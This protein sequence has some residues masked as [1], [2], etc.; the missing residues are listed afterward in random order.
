MADRI[1]TVNA[2]WFKLDRKEMG[3]E[4]ARL[5]EHYKKS[6]AGRRSQYVRNL[7]LY[8]GRSLDGYTADSYLDSAVD[9]PFERD[10]MRLVRSAIGSAVANIFAPQKPKPQFQTLGATW[11]TRRKAYRLDRICE[12][13]L[14]QR[15]G[16]WI[17]VWALMIDAGVEC[18]TQGVAPIKV[19]ADKR[20]KRIAHKV[21]PHPYLFTDPS[22]G[23]EPMDLF[24]ESPIDEWEALQLYPKAKKAIQGAKPFEH[25]GR[26]HRQRS[27]KEI[28]IQYAWRLPSGEDDPG[29]WCAVINGEVVDEGEWTAASFPFVFLTWEPHRDGFWASGLADEGGSMAQ[30]CGEIDLRLFMR[31]IVASGKKI[32]YRKSS[33]EPDDLA[34]NDAVVAVPVE[35]GHDYPQESPSIPFA[36]MELEFL[37]YKVQQFWDGIGI[38]QVSAAA[39]REQ[40]VSSG[41]AIMTLNDTKAG[42][43]LVKA[44]RY[45]QA[46]VDL[47]HQY[48]WRLRELAEDDPDFAVQWP[49]KNLLRSEKWADAE[50]DD[51]EF[52]VTVAPA[53]SLPHDPAGRQEMVQAMF[54]SGL[55]SQETAKSLIGWPD[56]DSE[57]EAENSEYEYIDML[58]A[59]YLDADEETW[60][61][62][63]YEA[64][65]GF[66][67]NK[68]RALFRFSSAWF[69]A[70]IDMQA[71]T[72]EEKVKANFS[73][74]LLKRYIQ[75]LE[76]MLPPPPAAAPG[77]APS[78]DQLP[79][80]PMGAPMAA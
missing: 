32:Y 51:P 37:Q 57:L 29:R 66:L 2:P 70:R 13:V 59:K 45:E 49:G 47:A 27:I 50:V 55:I 8:E 11:A 23:R 34:Q 65:E 26:K 17:N 68:V 53:S 22:Q 21:T 30:Q 20:R 10:R 19:V 6:Q 58:I 1:S 71:L 42:R 41:V 4:V 38:S 35:D 40:G 80:A 33:V 39:R 5:I 69:R 44:Q 78:P 56:L 31:E 73:V 62:G 7:E 9:K 72:P 14:N 43:Q 63:E 15:Q 74:G 52:S 25:F 77:A 61:Q 60:N 48:V 46:F 24:E 79:A 36:P 16:R 64:P 3:G 54:Q 28:A 12:G 67:R 76:P 18:C 75:E